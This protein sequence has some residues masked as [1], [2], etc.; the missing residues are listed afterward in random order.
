MC[1][2]GAVLAE[3]TD[4]QWVPLCPWL[5]RLGEALQPLE[6]VS[7]IYRFIYTFLWEECQL[8]VSNSERTQKVTCSGLL[9]ET[10]LLRFLLNYQI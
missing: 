8:L 1:H 7:K 4:C 3:D 6:L 10:G 5:A 9:M 2:E